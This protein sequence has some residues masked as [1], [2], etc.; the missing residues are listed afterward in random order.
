MLH[1]IHH[2]AASYDGSE[3]IIEAALSDGAPNAQA[4]A[5]NIKQKRQ[6]STVLK[7]GTASSICQPECKT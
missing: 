7:L 2:V 3:D 4:G 5:S 1:A 6:A